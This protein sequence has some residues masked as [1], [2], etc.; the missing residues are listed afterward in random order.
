MITYEN[1]KTE[2]SGLCNNLD[3]AFM[4]QKM[5]IF[6]EHITTTKAK[7]IERKAT[8]ELDAMFFVENTNGKYL[9]F[10]DTELNAWYNAWRRF[11]EPN[12]TIDCTNSKEK[13]LALF[14]AAQLVPSQNNSYVLFRVMDGTKQ[15]GFGT[16]EENAYD[17][18]YICAMSNI[19][20]KTIQENEKRIL[21][22]L[23]K[24]ARLKRKKNNPTPKIYNEHLLTNKNIKSLLEN[25]EKQHG[26]L[27]LENI[28][29][30]TLK[31]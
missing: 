6:I 13:V 18:T 8:A 28:L 10:G 1:F 9:G 4:K 26:I 3:G 23:K 19:T 22:D 27:A 30:Q 11:I 31:L 14:P 2:L 17:T 24:E 20:L 12:L 21:D 25:Y 7:T 15:I 16:N 5:Q 29:E